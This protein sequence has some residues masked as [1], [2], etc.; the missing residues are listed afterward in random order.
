MEIIVRSELGDPDKIAGSPG[1]RGMLPTKTR[2]RP[3]KTHDGV[4]L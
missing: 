1:P 2:E 3:W 4:P